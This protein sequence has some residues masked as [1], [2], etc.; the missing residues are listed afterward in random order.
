MP[1]YLQSP[2]V[3]KAITSQHIHLPRTHLFL[4]PPRHF[5][6][7]VRRLFVDAFSRYPTP[8]SEASIDPRP[9]FS[10]RLQ[11]LGGIAG[12][13]MFIIL[14]HFKF[15]PLTIYIVVGVACSCTFLLDFVGS[16]FAVRA[17]LA[18]IQGACFFVEDTYPCTLAKELVK[19]KR[20]FSFAI[21]FSAFIFG[22]GATTAGVSYRCAV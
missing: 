11:A 20:N 15:D 9:S 13:I 6:P 10:P 1:R 19:D 7:R 14:L 17:V 2:D 18:L 12:R 16:G 3:L 4:H 21:G 8:S 5:P 22:S